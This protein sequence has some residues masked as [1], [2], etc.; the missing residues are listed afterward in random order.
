MHSWQW[1]RTTEEQRGSAESPGQASSPALAAIRAADQRASPERCGKSSVEIAE[2]PKSR[3]ADKI[4]A[5]KELLDRGWGKAPAV[6]AVEGY[7]PL[8]MDEIAAEV[9]AIAA[10]LRAS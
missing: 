5:A 1:L 7:D 8:E 2:N 3:D 6:A 9:Q 10:E 4:A